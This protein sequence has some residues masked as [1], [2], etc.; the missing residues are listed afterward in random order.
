MLLAEQKRKEQLGLAKHESSYE[1]LMHTG[2]DPT[3]K[4]KLLKYI[5]SG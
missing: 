4:F 5:G 1:P 3:A 2:A